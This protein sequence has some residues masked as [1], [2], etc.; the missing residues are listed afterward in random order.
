MRSL[1]TEGR[2]PAV[3]ADV[4]VEAILRYLRE[5]RPLPSELDS[6]FVV[7]RHE[8][9]LGSI[10]LE[11]LATAQLDTLAATLMDARPSARTDFFADVL[12]MAL[13]RS[14]WL[15]FGLL[16]SAMTALVVMQ[17]EATL[18]RAGEVAALMPVVA[19][20]AGVFGIQT[21]T[22]TVRGLALGHIGPHN[23]ARLLGEAMLIGL[24][25]WSALGS[26]FW[27]VTLGWFE[28]AAMSTAAVL[29]LGL[30]LVLAP[31]FG[32]I[33]P[34][35]LERMRVDPVF[36]TSGVTAVMDV[37]AYSSVLLLVTWII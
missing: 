29:A 7:D 4:T 32:V 13:Q 21:A 20:L 34:Q 16:G 10:P 14:P 31:V 9:P 19:S 3:R 18:R 6:V 30:T 1:A 5:R 25:L 36:A 24:L 33:A 37:I 26:I 8:R 23:R 35:I 12:R 11:R 17:F 27:L 22:V 15:A 2:Y 28:S